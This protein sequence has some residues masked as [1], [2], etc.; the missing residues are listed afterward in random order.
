MI[1]AQTPTGSKMLCF[2]TIICHLR[3]LSQV[4]TCS[5]KIKK[6]TNYLKSV[7]S[8][9]HNSVRFNE[10]H[11]ISANIS[12]LKSHVSCCSSQMLIYCLP[13][14]SL[15]A[16]LHGVLFIFLFFATPCH[17]SSYNMDISAFATLLYIS[18]FFKCMEKGQPPR[19]AW[20]EG[21][22]H[23]EDVTLFLLFLCVIAVHSQETIE[24]KVERHNEKHY[25]Q[26]L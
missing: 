11:C 16:R 13:Y 17:F 5:A 18:C 8:N 10:T 25:V 14:L 24:K 12:S 20:N 22:H 23:S 2:S 15:L 6:K 19:G 9:Q 4:S 1:T 26:L 21:L 3:C 7:W